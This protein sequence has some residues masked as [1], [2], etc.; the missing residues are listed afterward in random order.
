MKINTIFDG[1]TSLITYPDFSKWKINNNSVDEIETDSPITSLSLS[2]NKDNL[3]EVNSF[4]SED[5][6]SNNKKEV[7]PINY[8][9]PDINFYKEENKDEYYENFYN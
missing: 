8:Y 2:S 4:S 9:Y 1:C 6:S 7:Q 5:N 3:D